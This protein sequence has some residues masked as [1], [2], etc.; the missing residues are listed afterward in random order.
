[1]RQGVAKRI[2]KAKTAKAL[3]VDFYSGGNLM[4]GKVKIGGGA[5]CGVCMLG[6]CECGMMR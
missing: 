4:A 6:M 1:L 5:C 2:L 3:F